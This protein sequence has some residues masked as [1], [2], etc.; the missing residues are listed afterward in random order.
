MT[1]KKIKILSLSKSDDYIDREWAELLSKRYYLLSTS[2]WTQLEDNELTFESR[3]RWNFWRNRVRAIRRS[4]T[5]MS[6]AEE[7]LQELENSTPER[8][9]IADTTIRQKK[10]Q[11]DISNLLQAKSDAISIL[12]TL[13]N[14][15]VL[16]L[17]PESINLINAKFEEV[18][19]YQSSSPKPHSMAEFPLIEVSRKLHG[20]SRSE[21]IEHICTL[22]RMST[23]LL[24]TIE[25]HRY[26]YTKEIEKSEHVDDI[27][28][29]I[30]NMHGY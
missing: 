27:I 14:D 28:S 3:I 11:L 1:P 29:I 2:D 17:L 15:W 9:F 7:L 30:K 26:R 24:V 5:S 21:I 18:L 13:H 23:E 12:K 10:Y 4:N 25:Q 22:K 20:W 6:D 16:N 8:E 19:R